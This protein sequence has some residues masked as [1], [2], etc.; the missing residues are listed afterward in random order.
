MKKTFLAM[1]LVLFS[2]GMGI[3]SISCVSTVKYS[4][5]LT[6]KTAATLELISK[7][8]TNPGD[9]QN[10]KRTDLEI[11]SFNGSSVKWD[12]DS[13]ILIPEG[14][15]KIA[16]KMFFSDFGRRDMWTGNNYIS[17]SVRSG[18]KYI[19]QCVPRTNGNVEVQF[20]DSKKRIL[21]SD[22]FT[23]NLV[24]YF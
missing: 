3:V 19:I 16:I 9:A 6:G 17:I 22:R 11:T 10:N 5:D 14:D 2:I 1:V 24:G 8:N 4:P 21:S 15:H 12:K 13:K 23:L 20:L 7:W 18:E